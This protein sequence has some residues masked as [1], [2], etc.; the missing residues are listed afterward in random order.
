MTG[1]T[2]PHWGTTL[3]AFL[4]EE[5]MREP[6]R[7]EALTRAILTPARVTSAGAVRRK[8][9]DLGITDADVTEATAWA[10]RHA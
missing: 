8:L 3:D 10:R 5:G 2:N 6:A 1:K 9:A 4:T 7:T